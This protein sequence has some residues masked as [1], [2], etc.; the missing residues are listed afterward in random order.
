MEGRNRNELIASNLV[1][2]F[3]HFKHVERNII[4]LLSRIND[5]VWD[6]SSP[7]TVHCSVSI[8]E[9][10]E[11]CKCLADLNTS[12]CIYISFIEC[13]C[14]YSCIIDKMLCTKKFHSI[15]HSREI[16]SMPFSFG[17]HFLFNKKKYAP[18]CEL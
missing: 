7:V 3:V 18:C 12:R 1:S 14:L 2:I 6:T 4:S 11:Y 17:V 8:R 13:I 16:M 10:N 15:T 9:R 5:L